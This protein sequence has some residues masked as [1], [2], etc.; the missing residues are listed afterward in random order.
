LK[1]VREKKQ[2]TYIGKPIK[3]TADFSTETIKARRA[4]SNIFWALNENNFNSRILYLAKLS[5]KIDGAIKV[6]HDKQ[7]LKQYMTTKP[8]PQ[9]ILQGILHTE[10][11]S[12]QN[13]ERAGSTK[14][15]EK[16]RQES[17]E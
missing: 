8:S 6:F 17:R 12:N 13:H 11:E 14:L 3:M 16:K 5:F 1:A 2:I 9:K 15:Q 10:N 7:K 4:W